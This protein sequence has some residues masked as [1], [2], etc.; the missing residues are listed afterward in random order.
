MLESEFWL[1]YGLLKR[2]LSLPWLEN[3]RLN[4]RLLT[5]AAC[6]PRCHIGNSWRKALKSKG[7]KD[8]HAEPRGGKMKGRVRP[9]TWLLLNVLFYFR[10][11]WFHYP[12]IIHWGSD[13]FPFQLERF[14]TQ[15]TS[16]CHCIP[17][18]SLSN[19]WRASAPSWVNETHLGAGSNPI[20]SAC[21]MAYLRFNYTTHLISHTVHAASLLYTWTDATSISHLFCT[22]L[23]GWI[24]NRIA[25]SCCHPDGIELK[26]H[27]R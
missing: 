23:K 10:S 13:Y 15:R 11:E 27:L 20:Q 25:W 3:I 26:G 21:N 24:V 17:I 8:V 12:D 9:K 14:H 7:R 19:F 4:W 1:S 6:A 22:P 2:L 5:Y 18:R 16:V